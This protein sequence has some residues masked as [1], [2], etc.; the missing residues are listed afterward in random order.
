M[1]GVLFL[2]VGPSGVGKDSVLDGA[3]AAL[4]GDSRFCFARRVI[5]R[6]A[7]PNAEDHDTLNE[8]DFAAAEMAGAFAL[9]WRAH[10]LRYGI[11]IN[12]ID[13]LK[14]G[15][16]VIANVSRTIIDETTR[17]YPGAQTLAITA[18]PDVIAARLLARGRETAADI[19]ARLARAVELP[20][21]GNLHVIQ[22]NGELADAIDA[23]VEAVTSL[24]NT[25]TV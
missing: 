2:V 12:V 5:T 11:P 7:D 1:T 22:N 15:R 19:E 3:R 16:S 6:T 21:T 20:D 10:G 13:D 14:A 24:H 9:S 8:T 25:A 18:R 17:E 23:F 4:Q